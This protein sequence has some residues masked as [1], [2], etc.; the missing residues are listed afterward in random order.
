MKTHLLF[1]SLVLATQT[2]AQS[3]APAPAPGAATP[4][5]QSKPATPPAED[6]P[7]TPSTTAQILPPPVPNGAT[8][9]FDTTM[10]R[11]ACQFYQKE[12]PITVANFIG[13]AEG[14]KE[15]T[16][17]KTGQKI[18]GTPFYNGTTFHRVIPHF[19]VQG[20]DR[21][22]DGS[23]D[24]GYAFQDEFNRG[25]RFDRAGRLAMANSGPATNGSQFFITE[26]PQPDLDGKHTIFGQCDDHAVM[27]VKAMTRV[28]RNSNDKPI[29]PIV[30]NKV[31]IVR[32]GQPMP[33][34]PPAPAPAAQAPPAQ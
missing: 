29:T 31:T 20:G 14:T 28:D 7:D 17:P 21:A 23:G 2:F 22:G 27:I 24:P 16:D 33:P 9:V 1:A 26:E 25:L 4:A 11:M 30:L 13:L 8:V 18:T 12:A 32:A 10:G 5:P 6:F 19:M 15:A 34:E 3:T